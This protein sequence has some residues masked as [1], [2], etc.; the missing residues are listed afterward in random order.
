MSV[1]NDRGNEY[2]CLTG[3]SIAGSLGCLY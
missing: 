2:N 3:H 1:E